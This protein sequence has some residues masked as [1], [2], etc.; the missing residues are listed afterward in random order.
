MRRVNICAMRT[1]LPAA[2]AVVRGGQEA[3]GL[4]EIEDGTAR[5]PT[6]R[7]LRDAEHDRHARTSELIPERRPD[8]AIGSDERRR[9]LELEREPIDLEPFG[10]QEGCR[11]LDR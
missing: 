2:M 10:T 1:Q 4:E 8:A 5:R 3:A 7:A 9:A 11:A 6:A